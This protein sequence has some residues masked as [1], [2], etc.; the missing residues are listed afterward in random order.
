MSRAPAKK[1]RVSV[2]VS[3]VEGGSESDLDRW[4]KRAVELAMEAEGLK[5]RVAAPPAASVG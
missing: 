4:A 3:Q 5:P 1:P 2:V